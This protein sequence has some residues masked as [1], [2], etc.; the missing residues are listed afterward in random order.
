MAMSFPKTYAAECRN[1]YLLSRFSRE[2]KR[3]DVLAS[4]PLVKKYNYLK[5]SR[6]NYIIDFTDCQQ[7]NYI[8]FDKLTTSYLSD[9]RG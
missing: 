6:D 5:H 2:R 3:P 8:F 4:G 9:R 1:S 7:K